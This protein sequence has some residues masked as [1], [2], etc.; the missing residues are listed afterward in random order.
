[1]DRKLEGTPAEGHDPRTTA[2]AEV[3][4]RLERL[5]FTRFQRRLLAVVSSAYLFDSLGVAIMTFV[6]APVRAELH[7]SQAGA[8]VLAST[9]FAGMALGAALA[10]VASDRF[11]RRPVF[12]YSM[13]LWGAATLLTA[14]AWDDVSLVVFRFV[15]GLGL[16]AEIPV[17]MALLSEFVPAG[18][19]GALLGWMNYGIPLAFVLGGSLALVL[20]P[21]VGWRWIFV[22]L[23]VLSLA[24]FYIR[25][26]IP[27][28][29]RWYASRGRHADAEAVLR[30]VEEKVE[31]AWGKPLPPP[32]VPDPV[33]AVTTRPHP[34]REL[35]SRRYRKRTVVAWGLWFSGL[36]GY[37]AIVSWISALLVDKGMSVANSIGFVVL[38]YLWGI[39]GVF[40]VSRLMERVGRKPVVVAVTVL[41]AVSAYFYA[42]A[43]SV[44][45]LLVAGS[46][47]QFF[48]V[49]MMASIYTYTPELFPTRSRATGTGTANAA[50]RLSAI[51]G[52]SLVPPLLSAW[53]Q[54]P[55]FEFLCLFFLAAA[56]IV[57]VLGPETKGRT[58]EDISS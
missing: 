57:I 11:G 47:L 45:A 22:V 48:L 29:P 34:V 25:R 32:A 38:M 17:A 12:A 30:E 42:S 37:Y 51:I 15:T 35:F 58:L 7:L 56:V 36:L 43:T 9:T 13:L 4:A 5:P 1:M 40:T 27:E 20:V 33:R 24:G 21:T 6:L 10:G 26:G 41:S 18:R 14:L 3:A 16:G 44:T 8:G 23:F 2:A 46:V 31:R 54:L 19:R 39:P 52:P 55:S 50:G 53:G 28:S 49:G